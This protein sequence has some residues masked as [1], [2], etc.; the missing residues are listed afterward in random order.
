M[1]EDIL[2]KMI[3]I[4]SKKKMPHLRLPPEFMSADNEPQ[5]FTGPDYRDANTVQGFTDD[6][7]RNANNFVD[8][9]PR[10]FKP[11]M[12]G[13]GKNVHEE[14]PQ[15]SAQIGWPNTIESNVP[16]Q[17]RGQKADTIT[18]AHDQQTEF[19]VAVATFAESG[20]DTWTGGS[21]PTT[22]QPPNP[23][24][25]TYPYNHVRNT[26][27]GHLFEADDTP[28]SE[29]IKEAHRTGTYYEIGPDGSRV[30]K[31]VRDDFTV[32]VGDESVNIQ[33]AAIVTVEGDCNFY[34]KGN[35]THQVDGDYNL[36]VKGKKTERVADT[37]V[38]S[39][40][41]DFD[42]KVGSSIDPLRLG[43]GK[44]NDGGNYKV[45]V[46]G[47]Y[48]INTFG[49]ATE[50]FGDPLALAAGP[51]E[52]M[53]FVLGNMTE[54]VTGVRYNQTQGVMTDVVGGVRS[55]YTGGIFEETVEGAHNVTINGLETNTLLGA[56]TNLI[57][58]TQ[59]NNI[60]G[61]QTNDITGL[62]LNT[63]RG[64]QTNH[65]TGIMTTTATVSMSMSAPIWGMTGTDSNVNFNATGA[66]LDIITA[67]PLSIDA[68]TSTVTGG[69]VATDVAPSFNAAALFGTIAFNSHRHPASFGTTGNPID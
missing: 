4:A 17:A 42:L 12:D 10:R 43:I 27:S 21:N 56:Q 41:S 26:E 47:D 62:Q 3:A 14:Y 30:T 52:V 13:T 38:H 9:A 28:G 24:N 45:D 1:S 18:E 53:R 50:I 59:I 60:D 49:G 31:I 63:L 34:T 39:Y 11:N 37:T 29:R 55:E 5:E 58:G 20:S 65:I 33:G 51:I 15:S 8:Y 25:A 44:G 68:S 22:K 67:G 66:G 6:R 32:I 2:T 69:L 36:L 61:A 19:D 7:V 57:T 48:F 35:F 64:A 46:G 16:R 23:F 40:H 54:Q